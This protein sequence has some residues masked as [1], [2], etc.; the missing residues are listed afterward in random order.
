MGIYDIFFNIC[1]GL[2][3]GGLIF[4]IISIFLANME[5]QA[6]GQE[7]DTDMDM[8]AELDI[9]TDVDMD[10]DV[11]A[12]LDI[13]SDLDMDAEIDIDAEVDVD[14][15]VE[16]DMEAEFDADTDVDVDG[17]IDIDT[18]VELEMDTFGTTT[19]P[20]PI[21]LLISAFL[22]I[23]GI[24]GISFYY[25]IALEGLKFLMIIVTPLIAFFSSR[26]LNIIWKRITRSQYYRILSTQNLIGK[27]GEVI[28]TINKRGG[29]IKIKSPTPM[30]YEK[31]HVIP[32]NEDSEFEK[33][34]NVYIVDIKNNKVMVDITKKNIKKR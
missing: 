7:I 17:D 9:D 25:I 14:M 13:D 23:F 34:A 24:S 1:I 18:D 19:T 27:K 4:A 29:V 33:G 20:A 30:K 15:D 16:Y 5:S 12:E 32:Y 28:F 10:M 11:D 6:S 3:I 21:M 8:D 2:F 22:L 26:Y 31:L